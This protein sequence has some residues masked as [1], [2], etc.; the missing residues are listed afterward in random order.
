MVGRSVVR[1][2]ALASGMYILMLETNDARG[3]VRVMVQ[4]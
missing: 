4:H 2:D 3:E 1:V